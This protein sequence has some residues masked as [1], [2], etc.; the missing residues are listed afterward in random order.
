MEALALQPV[1]A[2]GRLMAGSRCFL[3]AV[4]FGLLLWG[5]AQADPADEARANA[6][7]RME[8][9]RKVY[10]GNRLRFSRDPTF[11]MESITFFETQYRWSTRW[12]Q[13]EAEAG[14]KKAA[15]VAA[16]EAHL[17]RMREQEKAVKSMAGKKGTLAPYEPAYAEYYRLE[18]EK[19]LAEVKKG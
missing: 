3:T 1:E 14:E 15:R 12:A 19:L 18:A 5:V 2:E 17:A 9:A 7:A 4:A 16:F 10:Q 6:R 13:A 11:K 8:A